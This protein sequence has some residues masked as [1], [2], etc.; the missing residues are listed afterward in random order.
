M[1]RKNDRSYSR[2][3]IV[4][5]LERELTYYEKIWEL[6]KK[7]EETIQSGDIKKLGVLITEKENNVKDIKHLMKFN[8]KILD[9][10]S[11]H[12]SAL[13]LDKT[14]KTLFR[15]KQSILIDLSNHDQ[16]SIDLL[17]S[18]IDDMRTRAGILGKRSRILKTLKMHQLRSP[19]FLDVVQ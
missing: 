8:V 15:K 2:E 3:E 13:L 12:T 5:Y 7:Q 1:N 16:K 17:I 4:V 6:T 14:I 10:I 11:H 19:R 9:Q 18:S